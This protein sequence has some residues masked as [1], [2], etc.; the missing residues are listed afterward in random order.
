MDILTTNYLTR[1]FWGDESWTALIS[2]LPISEIIRVTGEDFHPPLYYFIVHF[3]GNLFSFEEVTIRLISVIFHLLTPIFAY[4]LSRFFLKERFH[5]LFFSVLVLVSPILF[6]YAFEARTYAL[7]TFLTA[8]STLSLWKAREEKGYFWRVTYFLTGA[9]MV[10]DHYYSWFILASHGLYLLLFEYKKLR[11]LLL[12]AIGIL[13]AQLPWIPT[14]FSQVGSVNNSY[15]IGAINARTHLEF[16][17]RIAGGDTTT[18]AQLIVARI[19]AALLIYGFIHR[20]IKGKLT[21]PYL[22]LLTWLIIPTLLPTLISIFFFPVFFY[23]YLI[24]SSLPILLLCVD[25]VSHV[26]RKVATIFLASIMILYLAQDYT[27]FKKSPY[28]IRE[29]RLKVLEIVEPGTTLYTVLPSFAEVMYYLDD[30]YQVL[31]S[32]EGL[33]QFSGKSLLDAYVRLGYTDIVEPEG[34]YW[35]IKPGP[36]TIHVET[37]R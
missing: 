36:E 2:Q 25:A 33:I 9:V 22:F 8:L 34:E 24:F 21:R 17:T 20:L 37:E 7:L 27:I 18:G 12:P 1:G 10:Y 13:V 11:R 5:R 31:V 35:I 16:F 32:P 15:W 4:Y 3:W 30:D 28:S 19:I 26:N 6:T 23:R 29:E 14:L